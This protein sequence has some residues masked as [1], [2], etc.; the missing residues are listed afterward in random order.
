MAFTTRRK[1]AARGHAG[2][3]VALTIALLL[4][5][6]VMKSETTTDIM[7]HQGREKVQARMVPGHA[8]LVAVAERHGLI[9]IVDV[10][11]EILGV[12]LNLT[13]ETVANAHE[14]YGLKSFVFSPGFAADGW[15]FVAYTDLESHGVLQRFDAQPG[16]LA[17]P[18][19]PGPVLIRVDYTST[20]YHNLA[21][22]EF[23]PDGMLYAGFGDPS[24]VPGA[25]FLSTFYGSIIR[26]E[27]TQDGYRVPA[28]NP[29]VG[30][31]NSLAELW[32]WGVRNPWRMDFAADGSLW[33][34]DVGHT[35]EESLHHWRAGEPRN[36][37]WPYLE[38]GSP[39]TNSTNATRK[40]YVP[41]ETPP[42]GLHAPVLTYPIHGD[43]RRCAL[44]GMVAV[45]ATV[46]FADHCASTLYAFDGEAMTTVRVIDGSRI[47]SVDS[48][49][50]PDRLL[51]STRVGRTFLAAV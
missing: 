10:T 21:D 2:L 28:D 7:L 26:I 9:T 40:Y 37:G 20:P 29:L 30:F 22:L 12:P 46:Y 24:E 50:T 36:F 51:V 8:D 1:G 27:P 17:A 19:T 5:G 32:L 35:R 43:T 47:N 13:A 6:C 4:G 42:T 33:I 45:E 18:W 49:P 38:G 16:D 14:E 48:G 23:G 41:H 39:Y 44:I 31:D 3:V 34:G 11:G 15:V 25:Q